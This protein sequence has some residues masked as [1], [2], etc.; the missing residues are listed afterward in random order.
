M[1]NRGGQDPS[2][3]APPERFAETLPPEVAPS[4]SFSVQAIFELQ[5]AFGKIEHAVDS[6]DKR[7]AE[8]GK[9]LR[10]IEKTVWLAT[11]ALGVIVAVGGFLIKLGFDKLALVL[12][13]AH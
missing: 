6:L 5:R 8:Q 1:A 10:S 9:T 11:G 4:H 7:V 2:K 12:T 13:A 3:T